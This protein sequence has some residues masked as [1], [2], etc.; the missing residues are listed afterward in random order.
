MKGALSTQIQDIVF[1][2]QSKAVLHDCGESLTMVKK[3][4]LEL[5]IRQM[6]FEW[7]TGWTKGYLILYENVPVFDLIFTIY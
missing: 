5:E 6:P 2:S 3:I 7:L 1:S 4:G